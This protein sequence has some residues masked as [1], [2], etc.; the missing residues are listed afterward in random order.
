M[1]LAA[2]RHIRTGQPKGHWTAGK[3]RNSPG[4]SWPDTLRDLKARLARPIHGKVSRRAVAEWC[5]VSDKTVR[6]WLCG[7]DVP[8]PASAKR[9]ASWLVSV[10]LAGKPSHEA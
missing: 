4:A 3:R 7:E 5:D 6:R 2:R 9:V 10:R 1:A 8:G